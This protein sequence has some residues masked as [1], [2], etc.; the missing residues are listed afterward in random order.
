VNKEIIMKDLIEINVNSETIANF[1]IG[2]KKFPSVFS[3]EGF[4]ISTIDADRIEMKVVC[5]LKQIAEEKTVTPIEPMP[6]KSEIDVPVISSPAP[7]PAPAPAPVVMPASH[8]V[9][10][11][12]TGKI[13]RPKKTVPVVEE[14]AVVSSEQPAPVEEKKVEMVNAPAPEAK[15]LPFIPANPTTPVRVNELAKLIKMWCKASGLK[16][17]NVTTDLLKEQAY[18]IVENDSDETIVTGIKEAARLMQG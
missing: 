3:V 4:S 2:L 12:K 17:A 5:S 9:I 10:P 14:S 18:D 6:V 7:A 1:W 13:G 16:I 11:I 8:H 15:P